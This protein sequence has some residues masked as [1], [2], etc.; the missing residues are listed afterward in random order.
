MSQ[1]IKSSLEIL[2]G[3]IF[4]FGYLWLIYPLNSQWVKVICAIPIPL[5]F[6][7]LDFINK[8]SFKK[9]FEDIGFRLDNWYGSFKILLIFTS[10]TI[11]ILYVLWQL[12]FPVN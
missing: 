12:F 3:I 7:Y 8:K 2:T 6:I 1:K 11:P 4:I 5:F 10:I 9:N